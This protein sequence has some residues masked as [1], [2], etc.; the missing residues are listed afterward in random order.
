MYELFVVDAT[1]RLSRPRRLVAKAWSIVSR[2]NSQRQRIGG[3]GGRVDTE[4]GTCQVVDCGQLEHQVDQPFVTRFL[5][6]GPEVDMRLGVGVR[7]D[8][9]GLDGHHGER[10]ASV[11]KLPS[12]SICRCRRTQARP[13]RPAEAPCRAQSPRRRL[14]RRRRDSRLGP[15]DFLGVVLPALEAAVPGER[16]EHAPGERLSE[17]AGPCLARAE[18]IP[19]RYWGRSGRPGEHPAAAIQAG[20]PPSWHSIEMCICVQDHRAS[21]RARL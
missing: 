16:E 7:L 15:H 11:Q 1:T 20:P 3:R 10:T 4:D 9:V 21:I 2:I 17:V 13:P 6:I 14:R 18:V 12:T 8:S 5:E 19:A